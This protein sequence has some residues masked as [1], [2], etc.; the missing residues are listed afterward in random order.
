MNGMECTY[1]GLVDAVDVIPDDL[2]ALL[3]I[4]LR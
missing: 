4:G 3:C 1:E 2:D